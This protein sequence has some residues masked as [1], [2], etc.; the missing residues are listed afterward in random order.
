LEMS[1]V[2][3]PAPSPYSLSLASA[4]ISSRSVNGVATRTG[5]K[6]SS[7]PEL[8]G[9]HQQREVPRNDLPHDAERLAQRVPT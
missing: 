3:M 8:P 2:Q 6:I 9:R 5:P 4:A 7:R 1:R